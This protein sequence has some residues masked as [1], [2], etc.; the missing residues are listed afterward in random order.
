MGPFQEYF[1]WS[2]FVST[3]SNP[4]L[5]HC[6]QNYLLINHEVKR[7][8]PELPFHSSLNLFLQYS[9]S[10]LFSLVLAPL[11]H[12]LTCLYSLLSAVFLSAK[13]F[14]H[15]L[16]TSRLFPPPW[17]SSCYFLHLTMSFLLIILSISP[18]NSQLKDL[19]LWSCTACVWI[20]VI[21]LL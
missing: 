20:K 21:W 16:N 18:L 3:L 6:H 9:S 14:S 1:N 13:R 15:T 7:L 2:P 5:L 11:F 8:D 19:L 12:S 10:Y 4:I 17:H